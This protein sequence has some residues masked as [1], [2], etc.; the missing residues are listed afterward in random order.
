[1]NVVLLIVLSLL[2]AAFFVG[3]ETAFIFSN[4]L[5]LELRQKQGGVASKIIHIFTRHPN[6]YLSA[7]Q[8]GYVIAVVLYGVFM[9]DE[10][11]A[12]FGDI[13]GLWVI[14]LQIAS[15]FLCFFFIA[16]YLPK[17]LFRTQANSMLDVFAVPALLFYL[18][19]Y[20]LIWLTKGIV[21]PMLRLFTRFDERDRILSDR[22]DWN[23]PV[24]EEQPVTKEEKDSEHEIK[25]FQNALDFSSI[26]IRDC[27]IPR[28]DIVA[29]NEDTPI[30]ELK[31]KF[32]DSGVSKI[33]VY[34]EDIDHLLGYV[35]AKDLFKNHNSLQS[36]INPLTFVPETMS[37]SKMM[38]LF[39]QGRRSI[40]I[41]VD[42]YGG[43]SGLLTLEDLIE[44]IFGDIEDEHDKDNLVEQQINE[45]EYL[46]S[47]RLEIA[48]L[49]ETY[50]L[51]IPENDD[52]DTLAGFIL[53]HHLNFPLAGEMIR[54]GRYTFTIRKMSHTRIDLVQMEVGNS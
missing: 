32:V 54:I 53:Y 37:G 9:A 4:R 39:M 7:M 51:D 26:K 18:L 21:K 14:L 45:H 50:P 49:N 2:F 52:Y 47:G 1:M 42:E 17:V 3:M 6:R 23:H 16:V 22:V 43:T 13:S 27:M 40:A 34:H 38:Q 44:E 11:T 30:A 25:I 35:Y 12:I 24:K 28:T 15:T 8:T 5:R 48:Y 19:F 10:L 41:V 46:F 20:P 36:M 33:I 29:V 31:Q